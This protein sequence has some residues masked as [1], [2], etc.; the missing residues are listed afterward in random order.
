MA[1]RVPT[2]SWNDVLSYIGRKIPR[3]VQDDAGVFVANM[4]LNWVWDKYDWRESLGKLPSFY[5]VPDEQDYGV[6]TV[7]I[8]SDFYGLRWANL[9]RTDNTPPYRQPLTIIKDLQPTHIRYLPHAI[10]FVSDIQAFRLFPRIPDNIG[11]PTYL[12]EGSY[13]KRPIKITASNLTNTLLPF[14]DIYLEMWIEVA[15]WVAFKMDNDPRAGMVEYSNGQVVS[16]NGQAATAMEMVDWAA[17]RE[18]L[19]LGDPTISPA[20]PL[21]SQGPYR[22][23]M[24]GLGF[25]FQNQQVTRLFT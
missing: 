22:P 13:K 8:P 2:Y 5:L 18:G 15:K 1:V 3:S 19:E 7:A 4:A 6:P 21:V 24:F 17:S 11:S 23:A 9:V 16:A 12:V 20:E 14:D 10:G 25:S